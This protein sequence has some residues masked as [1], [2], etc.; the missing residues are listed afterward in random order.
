MKPLKDRI[1]I[2][3]EEYTQT[4]GGIF[5]P[6]SV[7]EYDRPQNPRGKVLAIGTSIESNIK[8]GD[9]LMYAK[10]TEYPIEWE[11][12]TLYFIRESNIIGIV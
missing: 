5:I 3:K 11:G 10:N 9:V 1:L 4:Q 12:K 7:D 8:E 6:S 2:E